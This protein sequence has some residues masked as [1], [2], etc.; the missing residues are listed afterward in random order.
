MLKLIKID[1]KRGLFSYSF[2]LALITGIVA[3]FYGTLPSI[4]SSR[5]DVIN[6]FTKASGDGSGAIYILLTF[7]I[8]QIPL[9]TSYVTERDNNYLNYIL[10]KT[11]TK[12]YLL[13][14]FISNFLAG[15]ILLSCTLIIVLGILAIFFPFCTNFNLYISNQTFK[16]YFEPVFMYSPLIYCLMIIG[17]N[18][19]FGGAYASLGLA[20]SSIT[21]NKYITIACPFIFAIMYTFF[22]DFVNLEFLLPLTCLVPSY[23]PNATIFTIIGQ[24]IIL[25]LVSLILFVFGFFKK[26]E[27]YV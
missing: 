23:V 13:S 19:L 5:T 10:S 24:M 27:I 1:L 8:V 3:S 16:G 21:N 20:I 4:F 6:L 25:S 15:G 14:R 17:F 26:G 12:K 18:F 7:I 2:L 22:I 11:T 9:S